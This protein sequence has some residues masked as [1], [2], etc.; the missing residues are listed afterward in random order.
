MG[1]A[2]DEVVRNKDSVTIWAEGH[3]ITFILIMGRLKYTAFS[4]NYF[5]AF[6]SR[7][8]C[9]LEHEEAALEAL[10]KDTYKEPKV[11]IKRGEKKKRMRKKK[12]RVL[13][14]AIDMANL[15]SEKLRDKQYWDPKQFPVDEH[16]QFV[17]HL[18]KDIIEVVQEKIREQKE[19]A[20]NNKVKAGYQQFIA[21]A[22]DEIGCFDYWSRGRIRSY[23]S[24]LGAL[25]RKEKKE[26]ARKR[27]L[28]EA[29]QAELLHPVEQISLFD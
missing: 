6:R 12:I 13:N 23:L 29:G 14:Y 15:I 26:V 4:S 9:R 2:I 27:V 18:F 7:P 25:N 16:G 17:T 28:K 8:A 19:T 5:S 20:R 22:L 3:F 10:L 1:C 21:L 11:E 24:K